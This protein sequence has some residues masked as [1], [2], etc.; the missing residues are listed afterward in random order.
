MSLEAQFASRD[1]ECSVLDVLMR[2]DRLAF[3]VFG[4]LT[5]DDF[6]GSSERVIFRELRALHARREPHDWSVVMARLSELGE[7]EAYGQCAGL[8][9]GHG[10]PANIMAYVEILRDRTM[11]RQARAK[12]LQLAEDLAAEKAADVL[13]RAGAEL[14]AISRTAAVD[15]VRFA[16]ALAQTDASIREARAKAQQGIVGAPTGIA[17]LDRR[18]GGIYGNRFHI[19]AARP[20]TGKTALLNQAAVHMAAAGHPGLIVSLEMGLEELTMRA[21]AHASGLDLSRIAQGYP[22]ASRAY[23]ETARLATIPLWLDCQTTRLDHICAQIAGHRHRHGIQWAAIDHIGLIQTAERHNNRNDQ[24]STITRT[25]KLLCNRLKVPIIG[26]SQLS[27]AVEQ[28]GRRPNLHDLRD[29]GSIEQ[30]ADAVLF[31]HT[32]AEERKGARHPVQFGLLKNRMGAKGWL[33]E[34]FEFDGSTQTFQQMAGAANDYTHEPQPS[35]QHW[36]QEAY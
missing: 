1:T 32:P 11:R 3:E 19:W 33:P 31:L 4:R 18:T 7:Q 23:D 9:C 21:M 10:S 24:I 30:D 20:G 15:S 13:S 22:E 12:L 16:D 8:G 2:D 28:Q 34:S 14:E 26:L 25:L 17:P 35:A 36:T 27:R 5:V 6:T 29:S